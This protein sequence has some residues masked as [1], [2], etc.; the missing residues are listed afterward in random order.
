MKKRVQYWIILNLIVASCVICFVLAIQLMRQ[1]GLAGCSFYELT[2]LYC[3]GC[4]GT[5]A[6]E[7]LLRFDIVS[8][9]KYNAVVLTGI[10]LFIG[11]DIRLFVAAYLEDDEY[12]LNNKF[13]PLLVYVIFIVA[14]FIIRNVLLLCGIDLMV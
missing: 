6:F 7:S 9:L 2:H 3:P 1:V 4:G 10:L 14:N 11:Y 13:I 5:R 8:S 12:L